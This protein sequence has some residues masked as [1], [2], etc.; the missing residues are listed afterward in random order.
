MM[1]V[2]ETNYKGEL[3]A[4]SKSRQRYMFYKITKSGSGFKADIVTDNIKE[5]FSSSAKLK[6]FF[7]KYHNLSFF[8]NRSSQKFFKK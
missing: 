7:V 3:K 2:M 8:Y 4:I 1:Q 6:A 5:Q